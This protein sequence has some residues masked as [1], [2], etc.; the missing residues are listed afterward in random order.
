MPELIIEGLNYVGDEELF[1]GTAVSGTTNVSFALKPP[2]NN[3]AHSL[4]RGPDAGVSSLIL[5]AS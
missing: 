3:S 1:I 2:K 5:S 4:T